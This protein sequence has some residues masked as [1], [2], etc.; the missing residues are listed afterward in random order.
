[1]LNFAN[2]LRSLA[3]LI[4]RNKC[5]EEKLTPAIDGFLVAVRISGALMRG[6][7]FLASRIGFTESLCL[8]SSTTGRLSPA[9]RRSRLWRNAGVF[10]DSEQQFEEFSAAYVDAISEVDVLGVMHGIGEALLVRKHGRDPLL[11]NLSALEPYLFPSPWSEHLKGLR[12]LVVHPFKES[13]LRQYAEKRTSLFSDARV[14]P[15]FELRVVKPPQTLA[16]NSDGFTSWTHGLPDLKE[17]VMSERF[18]V[19]ILGCGA[20]GL[21]LGAWIKRQ[22]KACIHLGGATQILF[23]VT[24]A[25]WREQPAFRALAN[26]AWGPPMDSERPPGFDQVEKGCYW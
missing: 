20:Y 6:E 10:P 5:E 21:P 1:M 23:G 2:S 15:E 16:G 13:I 7:A 22:G 24:G 26:D 14:L 18:D 8:S 9:E 19:A 3:K 17:K 25:R 12:V 11:T 4:E